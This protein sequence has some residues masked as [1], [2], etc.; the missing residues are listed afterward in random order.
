MIL[1]Q[2]QIPSQAKQMHPPPPPAET[3][4]LLGPTRV[5]SLPSANSTVWER[6]TNKLIVRD[7]Q[8]LA[9]RQLSQKKLR[10]GFE[11]LGTEASGA[12]G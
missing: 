6:L 12:M 3:G 4:T 8:H 10:N 2:G 7:A 5:T 11:I 1:V 9:W